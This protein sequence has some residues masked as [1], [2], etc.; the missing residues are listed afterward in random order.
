VAI[1]SVRARRLFVSADDV[2][3]VAPAN[4]PVS[5]WRCLGDHDVREALATCPPAL[6]ETYELH[7]RGLSRSQIAARLGVP[8]STVATRI[9]RVRARLRALLVRRL[10][11]EGPREAA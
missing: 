10:A 6:R 4:E 2:P 1:D 9:H 8:Q 5:S 7:F 3:L 11:A